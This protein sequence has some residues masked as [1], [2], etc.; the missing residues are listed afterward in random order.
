MKTEIFNKF[1]KR[2]LV[3]VLEK[4]RDVT[5][6]CECI[7]NIA[8]ALIDKRRI[9]TQDACSIADR[10]V[11]DAEK[12]LFEFNYDIK[13]KYSE[14][15]YDKLNLEEKEQYNTIFKRYYNA[16]NKSEKAHKADIAFIKLYDEI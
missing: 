8:S 3:Y 10:E 11:V 9:V 4:F 1:T 14:V 7:N 12:A 15:V 5:P 16:L 13:Q 6:H 2:E